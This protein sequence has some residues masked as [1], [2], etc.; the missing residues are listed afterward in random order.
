MAGYN[1]RD[2]KTKTHQLPKNIWRLNVTLI[3]NF[4]SHTKSPELDTAPHNLCINASP[5]A[6]IQT[7]EAQNPSRNPA[8]PRSRHS[9]CIITNTV[10]SGSRRG[11]IARRMRLDARSKNHPVT[12]IRRKNRPSKRRDLT[13]EGEN[14]RELRHTPIQQALKHEM[15]F[16]NPCESH[17]IPGESSGTTRR[18]EQSK[19]GIAASPGRQR[20]SPR[21]TIPFHRHH[22][23]HPTG[24]HCVTVVQ[25]T[26]LHSSL[27]CGWL[28]ILATNAGARAPYLRCSTIT[29]SLI[30]RRVHQ[31]V[32][33]RRRQSSACSRRLGFHSFFISEAWTGP[34]RAWTG[35][36]GFKHLG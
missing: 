21:F 23:V 34:C 6:Q 13:R 20:Y 30:S 28:L 16:P 7:P 24:S 8:T 9:P 14:G 1:E 29:P 15:E 27:R 5:H 32:R 12:A 31:S 22:N 25:R 19:Q 3:N 26:C 36:L 35:D 11:G 2:S 33:T 10:W 4:Q 17:W 18:Q